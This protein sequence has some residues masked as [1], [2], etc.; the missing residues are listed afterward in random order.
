MNFLDF[1]S[2]IVQGFLGNAVVGLA[3]KVNKGVFQFRNSS[4]ANFRTL[5]FDG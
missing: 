5:A 1:V 4:S 3:L 2:P